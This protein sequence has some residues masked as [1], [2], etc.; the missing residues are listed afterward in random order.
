MAFGA[1]Q[2]LHNAWKVGLGVV[3]GM[4]IFVKNCH[5]NLGGGA[6]AIGLLLRIRFFFK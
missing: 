3:G 1:I 2:S 5:K 6:R 4:V